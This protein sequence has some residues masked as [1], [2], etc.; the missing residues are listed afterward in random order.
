MPML[1]RTPRSFARRP[2]LDTRGAAANAAAAVAVRAVKSRREISRRSEAIEA[3][4]V[5]PP[6]C[7]PRRER[8]TQRWG[9]ILL[10]R[11]GVRALGRVPTPVLASAPTPS[12]MTLPA[13]SRLGPY[14]ILAPLG[15]GGMGEVYRARDSRLGRDVALKVLPDRLANDPGLRGRFEREAKAVAALSHPNILAL[16]DLGKEGGRDWAVP[17]L[18]E[19]ETLRQR[20]DA[21]PLA[22]R[23]AAEYGVQIARG[24]AAA[25]D[26][27]VVHRD[28]KP[29]NLFLTRDGVVKILDFG[30]ARQAAPTLTSD[31]TESPTAAPSTEP[32]TLL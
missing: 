23:K 19:G 15:A 17:E 5:D 7:P 27:G 21:G 14:E 11:G 4:F 24:L 30:L 31:D 8:E 20:L 2:R 28:L 25:H 32:G 13:G 26:R 22:A 29:E 16:F 9:R 10:P 1:A 3:S 18:L 12:T 6:P